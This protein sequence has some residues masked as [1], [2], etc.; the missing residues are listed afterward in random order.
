MKLEEIADHAAALGYE[1]LAVE[2]DGTLICF[3]NK[4][5]RESATDELY[6]WTDGGEYIELDIKATDFIQTRLIHGKTNR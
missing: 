4:P 3:M 1:W 5:R 2:P 6:Y